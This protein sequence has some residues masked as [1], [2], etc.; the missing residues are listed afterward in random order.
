[1]IVKM[2]IV[3]IIKRNGKLKVR[4][5]KT[6]N[7]S[8]TGPLAT[9]LIKRPLM[10]RI[11][12]IELEK[13]LSTKEY[14]PSP[15]RLNP[16]ETP[17]TERMIPIVYSCENCGCQISFKP[18]DFEK[19]NNLKYTNLENDDRII[20]EKYIE[21]SNSLSI[22]SFLDFYCPNC[23]QPTTILF[24]GGP[25]GYWGIFEL[26]IEKILVLKKAELK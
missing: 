23:N 15:N 3:G 19:H 7:A 14:D 18:D 5:S 12:E 9:S 17:V 21:D 6:P 2:N 8:Y 4:C 1:M 16:D 24:Q 22:L 13:Y 26:K 11:V 10:T 25:S 20:V